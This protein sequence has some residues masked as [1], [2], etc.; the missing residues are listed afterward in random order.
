MRFLVDISGFTQLFTKNDIALITRRSLVRILPPQPFR[1]FVTDFSFGHSISFT[2]AYSFLNMYGAGA[3]PAPFA[4]AV[5]GL[6]RYSTLT[7]CLV[8]AL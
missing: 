1:V 5:T 3:M 4:Y 2:K 6:R 8:S 7:P